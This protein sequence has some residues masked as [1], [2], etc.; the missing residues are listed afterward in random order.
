M[1]RIEVTEKIISTKVSKGLNWSD[2]A[3]KVGQSK[4]WTTATGVDVLDPGT[5]V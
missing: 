3:K 5:N 2:V 1:N 4:E